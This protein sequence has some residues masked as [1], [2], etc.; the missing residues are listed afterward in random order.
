MPDWKGL[1]SKEHLVLWLVFVYVIIAPRQRT[2]FFCLNMSKATGMV[3]ARWETATQLLSE[4]SKT[5]SIRDFART[6]GNWQHCVETELGDSCIALCLTRKS[7]KKEW[8]KEK[9]MKKVSKKV[10]RNTNT[11]GIRWKVSGYQKGRTWRCFSKKK[12][13][14]KT[15]TKI[16]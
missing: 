7:N 6:E 3:P 16:F 11:S 15:N 9:N 4:C 1:H 5:S 12:N 10:R 14:K 8:K 2:W 13:K